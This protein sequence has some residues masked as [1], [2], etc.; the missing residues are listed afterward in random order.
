MCM[1]KYHNV[2][3]LFNMYDAHN[4]KENALKVVSFANDFDINKFTSIE[5]M[6]GKERKITVSKIFEKCVLNRRRP[7]SERIT[8]EKIFQHH[9]ITRS[10][11]NHVSYNTVFCENTPETLID[12]IYGWN[13]FVYY[14]N[15]NDIIIDI[16]NNANYMWH[17]AANAQTMLMIHRKFDDE[18]YLDNEIIHYYDD[19]TK[20]ESRYSVYL[21]AVA[22]RSPGKIRLGRTN[23]YHLPFNNKFGYSGL[24]VAT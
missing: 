15:E 21:Q 13:D 7:D 3:E 16:Y 5:P 23:I 11:A 17:H 12:L 18:V 2:E 4:M 14:I 1:K 22:N 6:T 19:M 20:T 10:K 24:P 9:I 8:M